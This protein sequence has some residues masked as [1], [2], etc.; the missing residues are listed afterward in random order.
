MAYGISPIRVGK[1]PHLA[2]PCP[3]LFVFLQEWFALP[4]VFRLFIPAYKLYLHRVTMVI[5]MAMAAGVTG[6]DTEATAVATRI[7]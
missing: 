6:E 4:T 1:F 7:E 3:D 5:V 2:F